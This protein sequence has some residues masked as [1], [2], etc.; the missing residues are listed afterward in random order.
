MNAAQDISPI[1]WQIGRGRN[2][3][4]WLV[5]AAL[6][7][8]IHFVGIALWRLAYQPAENTPEV[9]AIQVRLGS[10]GELT[11][12]PAPVEKPAVSGGDVLAEYEIRL[13]AWIGKHRFYPEE[14]K[15]GGVTGNP[16]VRIKLSRDGKLL[17]QSIET[18]SGVEVL[19][20]AAIEIARRADPLP[21]MPAD[22]PGGKELEFLIPI[23]FK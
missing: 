1:W 18:S 17:A 19:D 21:P 15:A 20:R 7:V 2:A 9:A 8:A 4:Y 11:D 6:A 14:A 13:S 5:A 3:R 10:G 23:I 12:A 22:Y 16:V